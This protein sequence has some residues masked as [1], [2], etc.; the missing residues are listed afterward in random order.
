MMKWLAAM[1]LA[2]AAGAS[3]GAAE[4]ALPVT[5]IAEGVFVHFGVQEDSGPQNLGDIANIG[6][7]VGEKCVAVIDSG[8]TAEVG[9]RLKTA[10][11]KVAP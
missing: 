8:G 6:F 4:E 11:A 9:R 3:T 5:S 10:V 2:L 1:F 7:I